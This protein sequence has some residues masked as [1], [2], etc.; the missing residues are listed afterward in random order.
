MWKS[1][2]GYEGLYEVSDFGRVRSLRGKTPRVLRV[3]KTS[4]GYIHVG[5]VGRGGAKNRRRWLSVHRLVAEAFIGECPE[6]REVNHKDE[7]KANNCV[8][9][10]EY[11]TRSENINYGTA[12][13]RRAHKLMKPVVRI[14]SDGSLKVYR[15]IGDAAKEMG[16]SSTGVQLAALGINKTCKGYF[17]KYARNKEYL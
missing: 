5:L 2:V 17:W 6:G 3:N 16:C 10:L 9:N 14:G 13:C 12:K 4:N 7:N 11:V 1:V 8:S 15:C